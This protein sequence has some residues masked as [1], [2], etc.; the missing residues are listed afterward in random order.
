M[1][2]GVARLFWAVVLIGVL[3]IDAGVSHAQRIWAGGYGQFTPPKFP[4]QSTFKGSFN[5]CRVMFASNRREKRGWNTDY[6]GAEINFSIRLAELTK[7]SVSMHGSGED[8]EPD[9]VVV[10][11]TDDALFQC[12][13]VMMEDAGTAHL[14]DLEARRLREYLQKGGFLLVADYWGTRAKEQWDEEIRH[15]LPPAQYP[16]VDVPMDHVIWRMFFEVKQVPQMAS[17]QYWRRSGGGTSEH[18]ADSR[19]VD[20]RG[21]SDE[22][23]R[24]MVLMLHNTDIPD[25]WERE[26]EDHEYFFRFSPD[27]YAV[28]IDILMYAMTH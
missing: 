13:F 12:P 7:T 5:F 14:S 26:G 11:L 22:H 27:A 24:L 17:I 28:G 9:Y 18:G 23:G 25:G 19:Q 3:A 10:R 20:V 6:P 4:T 1:Q 8:D 21:I 2:S 15:V 16:I